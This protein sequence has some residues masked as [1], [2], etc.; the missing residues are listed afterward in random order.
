MAF[1]DNHKEISKVE[2]INQFLQQFNVIN[3]FETFGLF[4]DQEIVK[5]GNIYT[6]AEITTAV[7]ETIDLLS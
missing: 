4:F 3:E 5:L 6:M 2:K 1:L 7:T